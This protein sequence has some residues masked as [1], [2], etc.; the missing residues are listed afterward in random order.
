MKTKKVKK[1][2]LNF[3]KLLILIL[4]I[5]LFGYGLYYLFNIPVR[6]II[7]TGNTLVSD[8]DIIK[9]AG[10]KNYPSFLGIKTKKV[11]NKIKTLTLVEEV[12]IKRDFKFRLKIEI[13]E[14]KVLFISNINQKLMLSNGKYIDNTFEYI[15]L[16]TLVNFAP[17]EILKSFVINLGTIDYGIIALINEIEYAPSTGK[18]GTTID[19]TRF[20]LYMND[21]NQVYTNTSKC[22]NLSYYREI[23]AS[24]K[25]QK[26]ILYLD[27]GN[28]ENFHFCAYESC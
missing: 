4:I 6:N 7:I 9:V 27:S 13:T 2:K 28:Y 3:K 8:A 12:T 21:G 10:L 20:I 25:N 18:D 22:S 1:R 24:I 19:E 26:G 17:E 5:Y 16:P 11:K 15:G 23:Y 14:T